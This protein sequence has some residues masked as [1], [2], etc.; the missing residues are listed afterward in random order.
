MIPCRDVFPLHTIEVL[1]GHIDEIWHVAYSNNGKYL[2]SVSKDRSCIIW[3]M[4]V[5]RIRDCT[6]VLI[7]SIRLLHKYSHLEVK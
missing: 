4:E 2:A 5:I 1:H 6:D 7:R 3:D